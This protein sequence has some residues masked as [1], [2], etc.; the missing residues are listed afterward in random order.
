[1]SNREQVWFSIL[2]VD[3]A[4]RV[5]WSTCVGVEKGLR[6]IKGMVRIDN[7]FLGAKKCM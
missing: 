1:M 2:V 3:M 6:N 5:F 7:R 4:L